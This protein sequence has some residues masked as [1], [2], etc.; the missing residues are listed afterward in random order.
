[1]TKPNYDQTFW[2]ELW[3]KTLRDHPDKVAQRPPNPRLVAEFANTQPGRALD[4]G[5]GHGAETLWL[6]LQGWQVTAVDFS[7]SALAQ[8]RT[9]ADALG[10]ETARRIQWVQGDLS[11]WAVPAATFDLVTCL[12]VH[13]AKGTDDLVRRMAEGVKVGG[14]LF[15]VGHRPIDPETG[16]ATP[17]AGQEQVSVEGAVAALDPSRWALVIAEDRPRAIAGSGVDAVIRA[18]R[19]S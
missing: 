2:E 10:P 4:A 6:A 7:A 11:T 15:L 1:M 9:L 19:L 16:S 18:R 13:A 14:T 17:A 12:Y 3:A 8:G 5:C